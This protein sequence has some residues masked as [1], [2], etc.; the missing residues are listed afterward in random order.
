V[1]SKT[2]N[3]LFLTSARTVLAQLRDENESA[4]KTAEEVSPEAGTLATFT[5]TRIRIVA[6][7]AK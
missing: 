6:T 2:Q 4:G 1:L 3:I 7:I 5:R